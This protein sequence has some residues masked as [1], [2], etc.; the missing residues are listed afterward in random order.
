[1]F[2]RGEPAGFREK[3]SFRRPVRP[4]ALSAV[5]ATLQ[6]RVR[7]ERRH[8]AAKAYF[9]RQSA[10]PPQGRF[11]EIGDVDEVVNEW[12]DRYM[13]SDRAPGEAEAS[14]PREETLDF[15][16]YG[17]R[18]ADLTPGV[19]SLPPGSHPFPTPYAWRTSSLTFNIAGY[20][21]QLVTDFLVEG[22]KIER[23]EFHSPS[24][25]NQVSQKVV[26]NATGYGARA[27]WKDESIVRYAAR[28]PG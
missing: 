24:E 12:T 2:L 8:Q 6:R 9:G 14:G 27:L 18:V 7:F 19:Q 21:R 20:S 16:Q 11:P 23:V 25:L 10:D 1:M 13:L 26:V 4:L 15:A 3:I 17:N 28:L 22:G 5:P